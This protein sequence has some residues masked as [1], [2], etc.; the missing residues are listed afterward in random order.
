MA[1]AASLA[2][3]REVPTLQVDSR[4]PT[5]PVDVQR[6]ILTSYADVLRVGR[7]MINGRE[8][9]WETTAAGEDK[10]HSCAAAIIG[11]LQDLPQLADCDETFLHKAFFYFCKAVSINYG[12][13]EV[14]ELV[15]RK[16]GT[17]CSIKTCGGGTLVTYG[18]DML[19]DLTMRIHLR[20][21]GKDNIIFISPSTGKAKVRGTLMHV[22]T[23]FKLPIGTHSGPTYRVQFRKKGSRTSQLLSIMARTVLR[24]KRRRTKMVAPAEPF[25]F[26]ALEAM[27]LRGAAMAHTGDKITADWFAA[28]TPTSSTSTTH[29]CSALLSCDDVEDD[30]PTDEDANLPT[31]PPE[32]TPNR[33]GTFQCAAMHTASSSHE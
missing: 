8:V 12:L 16:F 14:L 5:L 26:E 10:L 25:A 9:T 1:S 23:E 24:R 28:T 32:F 19:D 30:P 18:A 15:R 11:A 4:V 21:D 6:E 31:M 29:A 3:H 2:Q 17:T 33:V 7:A 22:E 27:S 20:F 13:A